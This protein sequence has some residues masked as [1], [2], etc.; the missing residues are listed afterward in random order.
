MFWRRDHGKLILTSH[1]SAAKTQRVWQIV[2][3]AAT[4][5]RLRICNIHLPS[6]RQ[7][8]PERAAA[9]RVT[10]LLDAIRSCE[11]GPDI[12]AGDFNEHPHGLTSTCLQEHDYIDAAV[13]SNHA[14]VPS[15]IVAGRVDY[16]WIKKQM[17]NRLAAYGV[18]EKQELACGNSNKQ[19]LS[20]HLPLWI[21]LE[22]Q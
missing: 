19:Y 20:D 16:I 11:T 1:D 15:N 22:Y 18:M 3:V 21:T 14:N 9:Q 6:E 17:R 2:E 7:L 4:D 5:S 8:R 10:E 13:L 12:I